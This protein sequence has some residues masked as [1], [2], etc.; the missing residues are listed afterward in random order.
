MTNNG[1]KPGRPRIAI[2]W[3]LFDSL[4]QLQCTLREIAAFFNC[5]EDTIENR[6]RQERGVSFSEYFAKKRVGGLITLRRNLFRMSEKNPITGIFLA[7][8][9]LGMADKQEVAHTL[10]KAVEEF[11]D[12]ELANIIQS[13]R[14][15]GTAKTPNGTE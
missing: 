6:V 11:T 5:S 2:D 8:N 9:W 3:K 10:K 14:R 7:K 15:G 4:C 13:R 1:G 12:E